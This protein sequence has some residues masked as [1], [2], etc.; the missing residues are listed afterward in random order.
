MYAQRSGQWRV[1]GELTDTLRKQSKMTLQSSLNCCCR[2][3]IPFDRSARAFDDSLR[4]AMDEGVN[5]PSW[6]RAASFKA[7]NAARHR[8]TVQGMMQRRTQWPASQEGAWD[9]WQKKRNVSYLRLRLESRTSVMMS[10]GFHNRVVIVR[11]SVE[12]FTA[13]CWSPKN[14]LPPLRILVDVLS[15]HG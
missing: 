4:S 6:L 7:P 3:W 15:K 13:H 12:K 5:Q 2:L 8:N 11:C 1:W 14:L 10:E 9:R